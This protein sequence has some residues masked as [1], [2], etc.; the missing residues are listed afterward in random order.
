MKKFR[1]KLF[2]MF[3]I[4]FLAVA[5]ILGV[6]NTLNTMYTNEQQVN[7]YEREL[8]ANYDKQIKFQ[9]ESAMTLLQYA[10]SQFQAGVMTETEAMVFGQTLVKQ[11]RYGESGYFWIDHVDGTLLAH[12][13]IPQNEGKNRLD[14]QDPEGTYLIRN[15]IDAATTGTGDGFTQYMWEKPGV[16]D[17]LILKRAYSELFEPWDYIVSTGNYMDDIEALLRAKE[18]YF[19]SSLQKQITSQLVILF[20]L[21][22]IYSGIALLFSARI[23]RNINAIGEHVHEIANHNLTVQPLRLKTKD[24]IGQLSQNVNVMVEHMQAIILNITKT[25]DTVHRHSGNLSHTS[26]EVRE[27]S[28]QISATM[29]NLAS[30]SEAQAQ[31]TAQLANTMTA[32]TETVSATDENG[33]HIRQASH[34]ILD[35][36]GSGNELMQASIE[37]MKKI[38][39]VVGESLQKVESL[40][41]QT[42]EI[43][44]LVSVIKEIADQTNLLALNAAIEAARAGEQG[45]GFAVVADEVRHLAEQVSHSVTDITT[46]VSTIQNEAT[47]VMDYLR[48]GYSEVERGAS[49]ILETGETFTQINCSVSEMVDSLN[50]MSASLRE[51]TKDSQMIQRSIEDVAAITEQTTAG[52]EQTTASVEMTSDK[53]SNVAENADELAHLSQE[54]NEVVRKFRV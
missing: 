49:Q 47:V 46:I 10:Y 5:C 26:N 30:G 42:R 54:L 50:T 14:I 43:S 24:E 1:T 12:P 19:A 35:L 13:E 48:G 11:L 32:F 37:Q 53:M 38:D 44:T 7:D 40:T 6:A 3:A 2:I 9:T 31:H 16:P 28:E 21:I 34:Q 15:I 52:I 25:A 41:A 4:L 20:G 51:M 17:G 29:Q 36:T 22:I 23:A 18:A 27:S 33:D 45:K 39:Y 8:I